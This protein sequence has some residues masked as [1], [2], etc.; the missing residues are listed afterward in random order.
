MDK[1][2]KVFGLFTYTSLLGSM[3]ILFLILAVPR[4]LDTSP[5]PSKWSECVWASSEN[6][7]VIAGATI[8]LSFSSQDEDLGIRI[9]KRKT[10]SQQSVSHSQ[11]ARLAWCSDLPLFSLKNHTDALLFSRG[12]VCVLL[13]SGRASII[14]GKRSPLWK[15]RA[16]NEAESHKLGISMVKFSLFPAQ[17]HESERF[18]RH[19]SFSRAAMFKFLC[20]ISHSRARCRDFWTK[21][22]WSHTNMLLAGEREAALCWARG[23]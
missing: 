16:H 13:F 12:A 15:R 6:V 14:S 3:H 20:H 22:R 23:Q 10:L 8:N 17:S 4:N 18:D 5:G 1:T 21:G 2:V 11:C 9:R 19:I 7:W